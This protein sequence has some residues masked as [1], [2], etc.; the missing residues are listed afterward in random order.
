ML[1]AFEEAAISPTGLLNF[2][3]NY[4][5]GSGHLLLLLLLTFMVVA[6]CIVN[7]PLLLATS[8]MRLPSARRP[9]QISWES[10]ELR[11]S[12]DPQAEACNQ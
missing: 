1:P 7:I 9:R 3:Y 4:R 2:S 10:R 6:I 12:D 11:V 8:I 5:Y